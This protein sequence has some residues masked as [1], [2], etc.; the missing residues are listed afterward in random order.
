MLH[1]IVPFSQTMAMTVVD[2]LWEDAIILVAVAMVLRLWRGVNATTRYA[3]WVVALIAALAVPVET[4]VS[5]PHA[6]VVTQVSAAAHSGA[7]QRGSNQPAK[8]H[9]VSG[10]SKESRVRATRPALLPQTNSHAATSASKGT[11]IASR[12]TLTVPPA[13]SVAITVLW[14]LAFLA[15]LGRLAIGLA[16]LERL[17]RD[18]LPLPLEYRDALE[19][20]GATSGAR[21]IRLCVTDETEV[22]VA[23]GLFDSMILIPRHLLE[24]LSP[25]ELS[26][27]CLHELAHLR[28]ADDWTNLLQRVIAAF[29]WFSPAIYAIARCLDREREVACD[30]NVVTETGAVR[31][32]AQCLTKMAEVTTWPHHPLAAPGAFVT[33]RGISERVEHLLRT[34]KNAA[35]GLALGPSALTIGVISALGIA[36]QLVAPQLVEAAQAPPAPPAPP[37]AATT[38]AAATPTAEPTMSSRSINVP[39]KHVHEQAHEVRVPAQHIHVPARDIHVAAQRIHVPPTD[40]NVPAINVHVPAVNVD[41]P[42]IDV[43]VPAMDFT[44]P[45][46]H[47]HVPDTSQRFRGA[48]CRSACDFSDVDW[49]NRD[50]RG[51]NYSATDFSNATLVGADF[52]HDTLQAVDFSNADLRHARFVGAKL[53]YVDFSDARLDGANFNGATISVCN[54]SDVDLS[55]VDLSSAHLGNLCKLSLEN[56]R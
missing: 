40:V 9:I 36:M 37:P 30:D 48:S 2:A 17:K 43:K 18:A 49:V 29:A 3:A 33:R 52:S 53:D 26:Q 4:A 32:Y 22:P 41:V 27:I 12:L 19:G 1:E 5:T 10:I 47:F 39:A 38:A 54:F 6:V 23:V 44:V 55:R 7:I 50:L 21:P 46:M 8:A 16:K 42:G 14:L 15:L 28:R 20:L 25:K 31:P 11:G 34:G 51:R 24:S 35:R 45:A 56:Q 13:A